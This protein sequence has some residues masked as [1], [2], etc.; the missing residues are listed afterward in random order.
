MERKGGGLGR[1]CF[2]TE[3]TSYHLVTWEV[4]ISLALIF[5]LCNKR[6]CATTTLWDC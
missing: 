3:L 4:T 5:S 1:P 2:L 6:I